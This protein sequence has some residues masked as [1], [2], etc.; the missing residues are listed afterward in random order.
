[1]NQGDIV[2]AHCNQCSGD[3]NH[4]LI[5]YHKTAR[6]EILSEDPPA[7]IHGEDFYELLQCAGCESITFRHTCLQSEV[8]DE[9]GRE[10]PSINYYPPA[11]FRRM[12]TWTHAMTL[13]DGQKLA[14][15]WLPEF[16]TRLIPEIYSALHSK[17]YALAAMGVRALLESIMIDQ[18]GDN[19]SFQK[20]LYNLQIAGGISPRQKKIIED[21][22]EIGHASIHRNFSPSRLDIISSLDIAEGLIETIYINEGKAQFLKNKVPQRRKTIKG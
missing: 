18:V 5:H 11:T 22:L 12:P 13:V 6:N 2:K 15:I 8:T 20:Q 16:V 3:R 14:I 10:V 9:D 21:T 19:G 7:R 1:M 4:F 17:C